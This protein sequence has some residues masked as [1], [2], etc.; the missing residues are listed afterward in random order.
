VVVAEAGT[1]DDSS[2]QRTGRS[3]P[4][5]AATNL[6][7]RSEQLSALEVRLDEVVEDGLGHLVLVRGEAGIGKTALLRQ[8]CAGLPRRVR[9]LWCGCDPLFTPR[10]LGPLLDVADEIGG[11]LGAQLGEAAKPHEVAA[12]LL[13]ELGLTAPAV[14][15]V[16]DIHWADEATLDVLRIV[17][18]RVRTLPLLVIASYR[19]EQLERTHPLRLVLG[20]LAGLEAITRMD[21][22]ALSGEAVQLLAESSS[23]DHDELHARTAGNPFFVTEAL[24]AASERIPDTVRDAVLARAARLRPAARSLLDAVSVV[25]QRAETWL[26]EALLD[27][28]AGAMQECLTSGMLRADAVGVAFR[29][30]LARLAIEDSIA[31]DERVAFHR[32]AL[33]ALAD[34]AGGAPDLARL[35][36]HAEA[37]GA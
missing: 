25:P 9:P 34:P 32:R 18:R 13:G 35:A 3:T 29:H 14:L 36:H 2:V 23:L 12:A 24:A 11:A 17:S 1:E 7:E 20:E 19:E 28:P 4:A 5:I 37:A 31:P 27:V 15:V 8:F 26:I 6:L 22:D 16:E 33:S 10:P 21:L 30:E